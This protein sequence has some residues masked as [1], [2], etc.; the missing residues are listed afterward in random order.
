MGLVNSSYTISNSPNWTSVV[1]AF[2]TDRGLIEWR[3]L[4]N[5]LY[6]LCGFATI[7]QAL[8]LEDVSRVPFLRQQDDVA[9]SRIGI[10]QGEI[11]TGGGC[12]RNLNGHAP[13]CQSVPRL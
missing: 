5:Y 7:Y 1:I 9:A 11:K 12:L 8:I 10:S 13:V 2:G 4:Y 3:K 6:M